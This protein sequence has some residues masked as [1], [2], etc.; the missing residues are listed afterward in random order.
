MIDPAYLRYKRFSHQIHVEPPDRETI[1]AIVSSKLKG[2]E[3]DG[4]TVAEVVDMIWAEMHVK[5]DSPVV[6]SPYVRPNG[7]H[8][9]AADVCGIVEE[10]CRL[11]MGVM[12]KNNQ[13]GSSKGIPLTKEMFVEAIKSNPPSISAEDF[14]LYLDFAKKKGK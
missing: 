7:S 11:A 9:S 5:V 3:L 13:S 2:I 4:I 10:T 8:Y 1:E 12:I 14:K 6:G